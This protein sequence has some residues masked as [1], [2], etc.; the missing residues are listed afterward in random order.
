MP[1]SPRIRRAPDTSRAR[2]DLL[3]LL[4]LSSVSELAVRCATRPWGAQ[5]RTRLA[6][7][8]HS[9]RGYAALCARRA[10]RIWRSR[11][12]C[13]RRRDDRMASTLSSFQ[14]ERVIGTGVGGDE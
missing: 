6:A 11:R 12:R 13:A 8:A 5:A 1:S 3:R 4:A 9:Y 14:S 2:A 7:I 10:Q